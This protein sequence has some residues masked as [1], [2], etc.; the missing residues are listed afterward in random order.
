VAPPPPEAVQPPR[1]EPA[2]EPPASSEALDSMFGG[3]QD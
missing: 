1:S 3:G 2:V